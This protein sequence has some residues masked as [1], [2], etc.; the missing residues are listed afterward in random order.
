MKAG[1]AIPAS[2][3]PRVLYKDGSANSIRVGKSVTLFPIN[4][5]S[6]YVSNE[7]FAF[8]SD[9]VVD[10]GGGVF[11]TQNSLYLPESVAKCQ[12]KN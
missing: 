7:V 5:T 1:N 4:H 6:P 8:T 11:E 12:Q 2:N 9:V 10:H 3:K